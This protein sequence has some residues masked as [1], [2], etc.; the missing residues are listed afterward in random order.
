[1]TQNSTPSL[2]PESLR[3]LLDS[4]VVTPELP[5]RANSDVFHGIVDAVLKVPSIACCHWLLLEN[6]ATARLRRIRRQIGEWVPSSRQVSA[7]ETV[8]AVLKAAVILCTLFL[9]VE[10][11]WAFRPGGAV[12]RVLGGGR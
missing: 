7:F 8:E 9:L 11:A 2:T 3:R 10:I 6:K 1:V 12:H 5:Q 4:D